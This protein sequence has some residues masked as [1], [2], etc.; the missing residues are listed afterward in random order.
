MIKTCENWLKNSLSNY[1][2]WKKLNNITINFGDFLPS[3]ISELK[4]KIPYGKV[5]LVLSKKTYCELGQN[6]IYELKKQEHK[7]VSL[8]LEEKTLNRQNLIKLFSLPEDVR[9]VITF[10]N[11][12]FD[13]VKYYSSFSDI[14][15]VSVYT[16]LSFLEC[17][18]SVVY[19]ADDGCE[20]SY[21]LN[22]KSCFIFD[23]E[24]IV[25]SPLDANYILLKYCS[26]LLAPIDYR[27]N[28]MF[29]KNAQAKEIDL[30][31]LTIL[32]IIE[33]LKEPKNKVDLETFLL[34][35]R[36]EIINGITGGKLFDCYS[37]KIAS[38]SSFIE[39]N[40]KDELELCYALVFCRLYIAMLKGLDTEMVDSYSN[41]LNHAS[42][43]YKVSKRA[44]IKEYQKSIEKAR[45]IEISDEIK[46]NLLQALD[47]ANKGLN[48]AR[49]VYLSRNESRVK[50]QKKH[51]NIGMFAGDLPNRANGL[52]LLREKVF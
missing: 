51:L 45:E 17:F 8:I 25:G 22:G 4:S 2:L 7:V 42:K 46:E 29:L 3:V 16:K 20:Y 49:L 1:I 12:F 10:N 31:Y 37:A 28:S 33:K 15:F 5:A 21:N 44:V 52:T 26:K 19:F 23:L 35:L 24:K 39:D 30:V 14:L 48:R 41:R 6:L 40:E 43:I 27:F 38:S 9:A 47:K 34:V 32:R 50:I 13:L 11:E 36:I 18:K